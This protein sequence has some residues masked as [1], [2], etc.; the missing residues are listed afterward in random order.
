MSLEFLNLLSRIP[1]HRRAQGR[2]WQ[3]GPVVL[4]TILAVLSGATSYRKVHRFI[5]AHRE[6]LNMAFEFGWN[7]APTCSA[8]RFILQGLDGA[9]VERAAPMPPC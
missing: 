9:D 4:A 6:D 5:E 7:S 1:D 3:L 8:V 2:K